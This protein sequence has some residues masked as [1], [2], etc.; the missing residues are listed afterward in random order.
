[1]G[2]DARASGIGDSSISRQQ[3]FSGNEQTPSHLG[4]GDKD[5]QQERRT[6]STSSSSSSSGGGNS[7]IK[8]IDL[9]ERL[10]LVEKFIT[11]TTSKVSLRAVRSMRRIPTTREGAEFARWVGSA[12]LRRE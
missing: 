6:T 11:I 5:D 12:R 9:S 2:P 8:L 7:D 1:M 3:Q 10:N 4:H